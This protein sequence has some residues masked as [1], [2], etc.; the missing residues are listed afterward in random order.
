MANQRATREAEQRIIAVDA[1]AEMEYII[2]NGALIAEQRGRGQVV[3]NQ[4]ERGGRC[5]VIGE[6]EEINKNKYEEK[7]RRKKNLRPLF[8]FVFFSSANAE[9]ETHWW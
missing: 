5:V 2:R 9:T 8:C 7:E 1:G 3:S 6:R 4:G